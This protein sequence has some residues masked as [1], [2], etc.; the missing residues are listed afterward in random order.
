MS[1]D[2]D[3]AGSWIQL[4]VL[5][6]SFRPSH[7]INIEREEIDEAQPPE[8]EIYETDVNDNEVMKQALQLEAS[9]STSAV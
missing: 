7:F 4:D 1:I 9:A 2:R 6:P 5:C 8:I 3:H